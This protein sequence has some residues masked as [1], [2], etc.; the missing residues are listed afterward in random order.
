M[1]LKAR[2]FNGMLLTKQ[3][4]ICWNAENRSRYRWR[5]SVSSSTPLNSAEGI[6]PSKIGSLVLTFDV[7]LLDDKSWSFVPW[8]LSLDFLVVFRVSMASR[9][10]KCVGTTSRI[11]TSSLLPSSSSLMVGS[12]PLFLDSEEL[13]PLPPDS[14]S[15]NLSL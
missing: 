2:I 14:D 15:I 5:S 4:I 7:A 9:K 6:V 1:E 13:S 10:S 11:C 8:F 12:F 3:I